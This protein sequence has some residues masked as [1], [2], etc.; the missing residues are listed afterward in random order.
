MRL[1]DTSLLGISL[2]LLLAAVSGC[3]SDSKQRRPEPRTYCE[4][5]WAR[6]HGRG[7]SLEISY[8]PPAEY[9]YCE[10]VVDRFGREIGALRGLAALVPRDGGARDGPGD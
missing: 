6:R 3:Q 2:L 10:Q 1:I 8:V 7:G 5:L 4:Q 9:L